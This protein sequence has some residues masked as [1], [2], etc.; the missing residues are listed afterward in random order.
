MSKVL[1]TVDQESTEELLASLAGKFI[2]CNINTHKTK[3]KFGKDINVNVWFA[4]EVAG[5]DRVTMYYGEVM[6]KLLDTP[7]ISYNIIL[8]DGMA[9]SLSPTELSILELTR[10]EFEQLVEDYQKEQ[11]AK[12]SVL[13]PGRDF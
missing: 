8:T 1:K 13:I 6:T 12:D 7:I 3:D 2:H 11:E 4:G 9:Y 5:F 10:E